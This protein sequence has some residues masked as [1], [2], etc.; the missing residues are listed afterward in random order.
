MFLMDMKVLQ[1]FGVEICAVPK[2]IGPSFIDLAKKHAVK[3]R[4]GKINL[5]G[6]IDSILYGKF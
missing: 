2:K 5:S 1:K 3:V 6:K 4:G